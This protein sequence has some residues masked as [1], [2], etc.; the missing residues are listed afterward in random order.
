M[1]ENVSVQDLADALGRGEPVVDVRQ[2]FEYDAGHVPG[3]VLLPMHLIPLQV[4]ELRSDRPVY[5]VCETGNRSWQVADFLARHGI[6]SR[7]V[8]GGTSA[9]RAHG[10]PLSTGAN[11]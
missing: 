1:V 5:L 7:N 10:L 4:E 11:A 9:W 3:A 6:A 2:P 8:V